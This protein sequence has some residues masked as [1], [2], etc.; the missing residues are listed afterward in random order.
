MRDAFIVAIEWLEEFLACLVM[1]AG[2][3]TLV[4]GMS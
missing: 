4:N 3:T 1:C 2:K